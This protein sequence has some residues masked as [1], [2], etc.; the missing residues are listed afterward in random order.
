MLRL[1]CFYV[2][3]AREQLKQSG[4]AQAVFDRAL[5]SPPDS[6]AYQIVT[7]SITARDAKLDAEIKEIWSHAHAVETAAG[8]ELTPEAET[9]LKADIKQAWGKYREKTEIEK[10]AKTMSA[11]DLGRLAEELGLDLLWQT[12]NRNYQLNGGQSDRAFD[13]DRAKADYGEFLTTVPENNKIFL[14]Q[15]Y[16]VVPYVQKELERAPFGYSEKYDTIY[17][18]P[19]KPE[20]WDLDFAVASTHEL[21]HRIDCCFVR[22]FENEMFKNAIVKA[23]SIVETNPTKFQR[24][25]AET[26]VDGYLSDV[27]SAICENKYRFTFN[28]NAAY[29]KLNGKKEKEIFANIFSL[30]CLNDESKLSFLK[31]EYPQLMEAYKNMEFLI[32]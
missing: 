22:S 28:H 30:E 24:F 17:Y 1:C 19:T 3:T 32:Y 9:L 10:S 7:N 18:D 27:L 16:S 5:Q 14:E 2:D 12:Q 21:A 23:K 20:F 15:S 6:A 4:Q 26:D 11:Q 29:W 31:K 25:C 8:G 13:L